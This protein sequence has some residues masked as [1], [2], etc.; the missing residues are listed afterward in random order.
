VYR[1]QHTKRVGIARAC[2]FSTKSGLPEVSQNGG[3]A[4]GFARR[5]FIAAVTIEYGAPLYA[6]PSPPPTGHWTLWA[7]LDAISARCT[8]V[9]RLGDGD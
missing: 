8:V 9:E 2:L 6:T 3:Y 1:R 4:R 7:D 5:T